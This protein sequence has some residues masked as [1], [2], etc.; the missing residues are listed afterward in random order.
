[1]TVR[2]TSI[3]NSIGNQIPADCPHVGYWVEDQL[4]EDG[5]TVNRGAGCDLADYNVEVKSRKIGS[6][7][8]HTV[9]SMT[10]S[11]IVNTDYDNSAVKNKIQV[12][13][14]VEYNSSNVIV[15]NRIYDFSDE[16]I[17]DKIRHAYESGRE[18]IAAGITGN[19]TTTNGVGIFEKIKGTNQWQ[20]RITE[21]GMKKIKTMARQKNFN[22]TFEVQ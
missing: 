12:Q 15:N 16:L 21:A 10:A 9:G 2:I 20:F 19:N 22:K 17:Q 1:M 7:S 3:K 5:H 18:E 14:R 8:A 11:D 4:E 13:L 6:K